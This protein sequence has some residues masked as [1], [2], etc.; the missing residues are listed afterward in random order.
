NNNQKRKELLKE[1]ILKLHKGE[2]AEAIKK[3]IIRIM[4]KVP[5]GIV[6]EAEQELI[7]EGLP[8]QEV[9]QLCDVH[10]QALKGLIDPEGAKTVEA[11]HPVHTFQ[12]ENE[13]LITE[14]RKLEPVLEK[15]KKEQNEGKLRQLLMDA[16]A[17]YN[18]L[19]DV[20]KHYRRKENLLFPY[21]EK[22][23]ITGPPTVMWGKDD[24][25]RAQLK[26]ALTVLTN[27]GQ[28]NP[29]EAS[30]L[31]DL[32]LHPAV[33]AV[34]EMIYKEEDILFPMTL[35]ALTEVEWYEIYSQSDEIGY[36]LYDPQEKWEPQGIE[37]RGKSA[38]GDGNI[39]LPTGR[40]TLDELIS[41]FRTLPV[42]ITF[43]DQDDTVRYFSDSEERIFDRNRAILGRKVQMCHPP[44]S[45]HVVEQILSDFKSGRQDVAEFWIQ[46]K[47]RFIHIRYFAMRDGQGE[48]L[49]TLEVSQDLTH[50]R[51]LEGE[52][53]LLSYQ[54]SKEDAQ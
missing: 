37:P 53:R 43:V 4:G 38:S 15:I 31:V 30:A 21:L 23:G 35:D 1:L 17:I 13:A 28:I 39:Q 29:E 45:V 36:C 54:K 33:E 20:D 48:Y 24:E 40:F 42:D 7:S 34:E 27:D 51:S 3:Q 8:A 18:A 44:S 19:M 25:I 6:V 32:V 52:Q 11:G 10:G 49:G 46:L 16:R 12:K 22:Y 41:L 2:G 47:G 5:Y 26:A 14:I 9:L 50:V